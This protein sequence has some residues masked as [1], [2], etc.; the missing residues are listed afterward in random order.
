MNV[1]LMLH[2]LPTGQALVIKLAAMR[3]LHD[4]W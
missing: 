2:Y 1:A 3:S 4:G